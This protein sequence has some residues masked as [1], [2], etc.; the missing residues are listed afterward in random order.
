M[1]GFK[2][3]EDVKKELLEEIRKEDE[4]RKA[5]IAKAEQNAREDVQA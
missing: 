5:V 1:F 4:D 3:K 2:S